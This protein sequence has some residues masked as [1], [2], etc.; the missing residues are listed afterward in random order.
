MNRELPCSCCCKHLIVDDEIWKNG[1]ILTCK[2]C[3]YKTK[4]L[5][6]GE[7]LKVI[8]P[9]SIILKRKERKLHEP[10]PLDAQAL[11]RKPTDPVTPILRWYRGLNPKP[12]VA[13]RTIDNKPAI[14]VGLKISF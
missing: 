9:D 11:V 10:S 8:D 13:I 5:A 6:H 12:H 4:I 3:G 14:E 1:G 7:P 2:F